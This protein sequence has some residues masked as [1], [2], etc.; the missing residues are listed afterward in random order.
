MT[1]GSPME[2]EAA[3]ENESKSEPIPQEEKIRQEV[4]EESSRELFD[5]D[6]KVLDFRKLRVSDLKDNPRVILPFPR[7]PK[8]EQVLNS[9]EGVC[10]EIVDGFIRSHCLESGELKEH[11]ITRA[12][13]RGI[14]KLQQRA[15]RGEI[16]I[17]STDKSGKL[18]VSTRECYRQQGK[19][20]VQG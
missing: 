5:Q 10:V 16:V 14:Y 17:T 6:R 15:L 2:Q 4:T 1:A 18:C 8:E 11:N 9:Q 7:P 19:P 13:K 12:Q 3:N 20:H